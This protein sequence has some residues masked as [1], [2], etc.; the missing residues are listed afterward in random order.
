M[1]TLRFLLVTTFYPPY[2]IGGDAV[3]VRYLA[4]ALAARGHEVHVEFA[5]EAFRLKRPRAAPSKGPADSVELHPIPSRFG[6][7]LPLA[8]Y[9]LGRSRGTSRFHADLVRKV[10]PDVIHHHNISLLG[11]GVLERRSS[12]RVLYTAHDYWLRCPR[13]DLFKYGRY[14]CDRPTCARC[15]IA[16]KRPPQLWRL[17]GLL[18]SLK[19]LDCA[20][21]PSD[22]MRRAIQD[23]VPCP[24]V[25]IPNFAPDPNPKRSLSTPD[26][27]Y[28]Y[29][30]VLE[31]HKG[32][33]E[34]A[35]A[36]PKSGDTF[37]VVAGQGS[38]LPHLRRLEASGA[39]IHVRGW[40]ETHDLAPLYRRARALVL[41][42]LSHENAPLAA[43]E[44]M[45]WG[46]PLLVSRRGGL[47]ELLHKG[48]SGRSFE[49][50]PLD[51][52]DALARFDRENLPE[53]LR[54]GA[55]AC[56]ETFHNPEAYLSAYL[57]VATASPGEPPAPAPDTL[58][59]PDQ[60]PASGTRA[61][62]E[63]PA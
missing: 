37:L 22:F 57:T 38:L 52:A 34:L 14:P 48:R 32:I 27:Y 8:A 39:H 40:I 16:S 30:G 51:I 42:S 5:P 60:S 47:E 50:A 18:R 59:L 45:S 26:G 53:R 23:F 58:G 44:A 29:V 33:R 35:E 54:S 15:A 31:A 1:E 41:P 63:G 46:T 62:G 2:H 19:A 12:A 61:T 49:P 13:S 6:R 11:L 9:V 25:H 56:Y 43:I 17:G 10:S 4:N 21:A 55:R 3:H 7:A 28:L 36:I 24:V 20:I